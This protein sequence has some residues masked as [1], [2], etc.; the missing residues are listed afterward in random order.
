MKIFLTLFVLLFSSSVLAEKIILD[1]RC[2][3]VHDNIKFLSLPCFGRDHI[4]ELDLT[5]KNVDFLDSQGKYNFDMIINKYNGVV[6]ITNIN[7]TEIKYSIAYDDYIKFNTLNRYTGVLNE[8]VSASKDLSSIRTI[9]S[10]CKKGNPL[11]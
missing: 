5:A 10:V 2:E 4:I 6:A 11:F 9:K 8:T 1:C 3:E 7:E